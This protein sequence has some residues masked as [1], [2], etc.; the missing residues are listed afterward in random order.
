MK[1]Q[2]RMVPA[3]LYKVLKVECNFSSLISKKEN[4]LLKKGTKQSF[5]I[6]TILNTYWSR[7]I[8]CWLAFF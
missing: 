8:S 6:F 1:Y 5:I 3:A 4:Y 2:V 7:G